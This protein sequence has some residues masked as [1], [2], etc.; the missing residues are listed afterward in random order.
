[1]AQHRDT[2][3]LAGVARKPSYT[4]AGTCTAAQVTIQAEAG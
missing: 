4:L 1:M 3:G 2:D